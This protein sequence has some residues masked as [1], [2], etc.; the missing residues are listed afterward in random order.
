MR[1][2]ARLIEQVGYSSVNMEMIAAAAGLKKP[3]LYHYIKSKDEILFLMQ[4][5]V[6]QR[7]LQGL[8]QRQAAKQGC[9]AVLKGVY[10]DIFTQLLDSPGTVR[11]FFEHGRDLTPEQRSQIHQEREIFNK[12]VTDVIR[13]GIAQG[14]LR[15]ANTRLMTLCFFGVVNFAYQWYRPGQD[16]EPA[17]MAQDCF[18][19]FCQGMMTR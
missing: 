7:S 2:A 3:T 11:S 18:D 14:V 19:M 5:R 4:M 8:R 13:E 9:L 17:Q 6:I 10:Q 16:P 1:E 12:A 15:A